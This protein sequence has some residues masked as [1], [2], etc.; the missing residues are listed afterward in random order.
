[1]AGYENKDG[2]LIRDEQSS[3]I[4]TT[5]SCPYEP[6]LEMRKKCLGIRVAKKAAHN[7]STVSLDCT[8]IPPS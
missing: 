4:Y 1:M 3:S 8:D 6:D 7:G 2:A 5:S